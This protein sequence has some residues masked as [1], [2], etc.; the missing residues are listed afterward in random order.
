MKT[1][2]RFGLFLLIATTALSGCGGG[3]GDDPPPP[4]ESKL[5]VDLTSDR[6]S[7]RVGEQLTLTWTAEAASSCVGSGDWSGSKTVRGSEKVALSKVGT[8]TYILTCN[9]TGGSSTDQLSIATGTGVTEL[10]IPGLPAPINYAPGKCVPSQDADYTISCIADVSTI[11]SK[12]DS[13]SSQS[14]SRVRFS[15]TTQPIA[16]VGGACVG[17]FDRLQGRLTVDSTFYDVFL[18]VTGADVSEMVFSPAA[19]SE[20]G[21]TEMS[22]LVFTD[23][24]NTDRIGV[25]LYVEVDGDTLV[26]AMAGT[27]SSTGVADFVLC[28]K[29]DQPAPPP[30]PPPGSLTCPEKDGTGANGVSFEGSL[31]YSIANTAANQSSQRSV[32]WGARFNN[33]SLSSGA[34]SGSL[35]VSLWAVPSSFSGSGTIS[36]YQLFEGYPNFTGSGARSSSQ[37]YNFASATNIVSSGT[38]KNPPPGRYCV[39][40]ALDHFSTTCTSA[41]GYCYAD[42]AQ[43]DKAV[44]FP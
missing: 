33:S 31:S 35:R 7:A 5:T 9:G 39:V 27:V 17:G 6:S 36:G 1:N 32:T 23:G 28:L 30:P 25:I 8:A 16:D 26:S 41:S 37:L 20:Y 10:T 38:G 18:P 40:A 22:T 21:I 14:S 19:L 12:Y 3:G 15:P 44:Q 13:F 11:P 4:V 2:T 34:Y 43:F 24:S 29:D 42:W